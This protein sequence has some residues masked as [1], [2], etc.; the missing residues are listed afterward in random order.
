[1]KTKVL[2]LAL[3]LMFLLTAC[4]SAPAE[5]TA[6]PTT[7]ADPTETTTPVET[8]APV[9]TTTA[10]PETT[11]PAELVRYP[12]N[13]DSTYV[14]LAQELPDHIYT[15]TGTE[16]GLVGTVY[17]FTGTVVDTAIT[18][19]EGTGMEQIFVETDGGQVMIANLY[20]CL[21]NGAYKAYGKSAADREYPYPVSDYRLPGVGESGEFLCIYVGFSNV[22]EV[23]VFYAGANPALFEAMEC[24][25]PTQ[26][27]MGTP[28]NPYMPG[29]YKVG[30]DLPAGEYCFVAS[31]GT[32]YACVSEDSNQDDILENEMFE[33]TWFV[34]VSD[35]QYLETSRCGFVVAEDVVLNIEPDGSFE[36]GMYRVGIDIPAGEYK[37]TTDDS[38]YYCI[39]KNSVPPFDIV[40]NDIFDGSSYVTVK[41]GQYLMTSGCIAV[42][43]K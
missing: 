15:T 14:N 16:N 32:G 6:P 39:Y 29:M 12:L 26:V 1:M 11:A 36:E 25:D 24:Q 9:A 31:G 10:P 37:L 43:V 23:P 34:T 41:N 8:T 13:A 20:K 2:A 33:H 18:E 28:E 3:A 5:T 19:V 35:G 30:S 22:A 27:P 38:G 40:S 17:M 21:Y 7:T 42:P 4:G